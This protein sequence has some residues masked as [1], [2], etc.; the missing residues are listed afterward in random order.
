M[1]L[2][3]FLLR[4]L[5]PAAIPPSSGAATS[6][7]ADP[8]ASLSSSPPFR[9]GV[10]DG[11]PLPLRR[12]GVLFVAAAPPRDVRRVVRGEAAG[13]I[14][15]SSTTLSCSSS[16]VLGSRSSSSISFFS[17][18]SSSAKSTS[19]TGL[20]GG[21]G[22]S[23]LGWLGSS[24][25]LE[26]ENALT[27]LRFWPA[28]CGLERAPPPP[29]SSVSMREPDERRSVEMGRG[30]RAGRAVGRERGARGGGSRSA[31]REVAGVVIEAS[32]GAM[33]RLP[34]R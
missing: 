11:R 5:T 34:A 31:E 14:T 23:W 15:S 27:T 6:G 32:D 8:L 1:Y 3:A 9:F 33:R 29:P 4:L 22:G 28:T 19:I 13:L 21:G 25:K 26:S 18:F 30:A 16:T 24:L 10:A 7:L 12:A 2:A 20:G 17:A